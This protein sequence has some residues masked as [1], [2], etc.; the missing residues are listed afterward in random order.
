MK[1]VDTFDPN[2]STNSTFNAG[3]SN[4][5]GKIVVYNESNANLKLSWGS[6]STY[7]PAWT[8]ML[9]CISTNNVNISWEV[10][11]SL[12]SNG[13]PISQ[14]IIEAYNNDEPILGT[15][16]APLVRQTNVGNASTV[17]TAASSIQNNG[18]VAGSTVIESTV[19]GDT[20]SAV[21]LT[22]QGHLTL[23]TANNPG[24][25][26]II[27]EFGT[28]E[29]VLV[30]A[31]GQ[32]TVTNKILANLI[33]ALTNNDLTL[34]V[35]SGHKI[36]MQINNADVVDVN[37][38]GLTIL[39]GKINLLSGALSRVSKF[40]GS[41][42]SAGALFNHGLGDIPDMVFIQETNSSGDLNT[43]NFDPA[44]LTSTQVRIWS[45]GATPRNFSA[46]AFKF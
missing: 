37:S 34:N 40:S 9:Y 44:S 24:T 13:A 29:Q 26:T 21:L 22:N 25:L 33:V 3:F 19:V 5:V 23:G 10:Q 38:N 43:F 14:V 16:P 20:A 15:F 17:L 27:S 18:Q 2:T 30:D 35:A 46:V 12:I 1:I 36:A 28:A 31:L 39:S 7:C 42:G 32:L 4:G 45:A 8:A 41:V 6:F 11:S